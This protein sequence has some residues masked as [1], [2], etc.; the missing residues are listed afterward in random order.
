MR[1]TRLVI[2]L[3]PPNLIMQ[4]K[5]KII[6]PSPLCQTKSQK[7]LATKGRNLTFPLLT[8]HSSTACSH[9]CWCAMI[10]AQF[11]N[12]QLKIKLKKFSQRFWTLKNQKTSHIQAWV[13]ITQV[14]RPDDS[15][16]WRAYQV[17]RL[18]ILYNSQ[19]KKWLFVLIIE[20]IVQNH[21]F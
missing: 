13:K 21:Y 1:S 3:M 12:S 6:S 17:P 18:R 14:L 8:S 5:P 19:W 9:L 2:H 15:L 16:Q 11:R 4:L 7:L 10:L 20:K